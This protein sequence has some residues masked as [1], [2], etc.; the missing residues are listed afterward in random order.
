MTAT[1][2]RVDRY[3]LSLRLLHWVRATLIFGLL[4]VGFL[5]VR[6]ADDTP[7]KFETL[8]PL[9][10]EFGVLLFL[11]VVVQL[12]IRSRAALPALPAGLSRWEVLLSKTVHRA[13]LV[14]IVVVPLMGYSMSSTFTQSDGVPFFFMEMP[15]LLPKNDDAFAVFQAL[16]RYCAYT[17]LALIAL[18]V[19]GVLKHR[20]IDRDGTDV[21][22][23][24]L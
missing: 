8:Y 22:P 6:L 10:K 19:A 17:L 24:M 14:L 15:E 7:G 21:L 3:P 9:H 23:R 12:I 20:F 11:I 1:V 5:M 16:H 18:H 2:A 4:A 13:M